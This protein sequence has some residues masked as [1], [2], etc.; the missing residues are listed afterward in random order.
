MDTTLK[1]VVIAA[2]VIVSIAAGY[3]AIRQQPHIQTSEEHLD[4]TIERI[5]AEHSGPFRV[6]LY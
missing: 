1:A 3:I 6:Q 2:C 4:A 5:R